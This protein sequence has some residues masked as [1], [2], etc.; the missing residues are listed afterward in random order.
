MF[1]YKIN[2]QSGNYLQQQHNYYISDL[3]DID[4]NQ[5]EFCVVWATRI[6]FLDVLSPCRQS[7]LSPEGPLA[8]YLSPWK[9]SLCFLFPTKI[10]PCFLVLPAYMFPAIFS[11]VPVFPL[12]NTPCS[13][14]VSWKSLGNLYK[15]VYFALT[16]RGLGQ[17]FEF[18]HSGQFLLTTIKNR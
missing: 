6:L 5:W 15:R 17:R 16:I 11:S 2:I 10:Q 8:V 13:C 3:I 4:F 18:G 9:L 7:L 1:I 14:L 12:Q